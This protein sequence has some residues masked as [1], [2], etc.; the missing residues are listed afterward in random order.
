[1]KAKGSARLSDRLLASSGKPL[2]TTVRGSCK[3]YQNQCHCE[4]GEHNIQIASNWH[5]QVWLLRLIPVQ[6]T[7]DKLIRELRAEIER[8]RREVAEQKPADSVWI[9]KWK[10]FVD[11]CVETDFLELTFELWWGNN[12]C[13]VLENIISLFET[14]RSASRPTVWCHLETTRSG[15][16]CGPGGAGASTATTWEPKDDWA[17]VTHPHKN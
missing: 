13:L 9:W 3:A 11:I 17:D 14:A 7:N 1:M 15:V 2:D 12:D 5:A 4:W 10:S 16:R 6:D 8:L